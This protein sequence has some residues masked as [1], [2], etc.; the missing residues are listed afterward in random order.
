MWLDPRFPKVCFKGAGVLYITNNSRKVFLSPSSALS[1]LYW[2]AAEA[3]MDL[4]LDMPLFIFDVQEALD[5]IKWLMDEASERLD[6][7]CG[8]Y[9]TDRF[10]PPATDISDHCS[11]SEKIEVVMK[12][13]N[14]VSLCRD[15]FEDDPEILEELHHQTAAKAMVQSISHMHGQAI[16]EIMAERKP[17]YN[18]YLSLK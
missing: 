13:A 7:I 9:S 18:Q 2:L 17:E 14:S 15:D 12:L 11:F 3:L 5:D 10:F 4:E 8:G 16:T 6:A 1:H